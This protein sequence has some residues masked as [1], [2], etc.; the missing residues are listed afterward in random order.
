VLQVG[1]RYTLESMDATPRSD[2]SQNEPRSTTVTRL[3]TRP[4][5]HDHPAALMASL[6][7]WGLS[8]F[9]F[10]GLAIPALRSLIDAIDEAVHD[11]VVAAEWEPLVRA[12][13]GLNVIGSV[14]VTLPLIGAVA[15]WLS[16]RRH[17]EALVTW[18]LT[19]ALSQLLI[20]PVKD[21]YAR[22]RPPDS[23][24]QTTG[25][26][27]PSGHSVAGAAIA[28]AAVIVLV[29]AGPARRNLEMVAAAFAVAMA[30]SRVYLRAH[31]FADVAAGAALGIAI[32]VGVA[33]G[34]HAI[35]N[36]RRVAQGEEPE[37]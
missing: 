15:V 35:D 5:L 22:A 26:S 24:I 11:L 4:L 17:W 7:A 12:S 28:V 27:F 3:D 32:A 2:G 36:R 14:W 29:P 1:R 31:W 10:L 20:G 25:Y 16:V 34:V 19:M 8:A 23:L 21:L 9:I 30:L 18:F 37:P 6:L 13:D 33:A